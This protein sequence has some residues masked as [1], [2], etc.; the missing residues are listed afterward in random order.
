[1]TGHCD[2]CLATGRAVGHREIDKLGA[3]HVNASTLYNVLSTP[4]VLNKSVDK[5]A[6]GFEKKPVP[7]KPCGFSGS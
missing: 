7:S 1:M 3:G 4:P 5:P 2:L 6:F